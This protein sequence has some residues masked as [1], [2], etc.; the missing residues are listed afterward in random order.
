[1]D[2]STDDGNRSQLSLICRIV[3]KS[4]GTIENRFLDLLN[5]SGC[6]DETI[7][8]RVESFLEDKKL[9]K[10]RRRFAGMDGCS[11]MS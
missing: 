9:D 7:F 3:E 8:R 10:T 4:T 5:L 2:E 1:M 6:D 11:T